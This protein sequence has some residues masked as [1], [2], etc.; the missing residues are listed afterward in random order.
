LEDV[1]VAGRVRYRHVELFAIWE[2]IG[3]Y[4]FDVVW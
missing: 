4:D 1:D 2:E 3:C